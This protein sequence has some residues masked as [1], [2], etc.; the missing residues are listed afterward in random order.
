M[1]Q[2]QPTKK[3]GHC[4]HR[5]QLNPETVRPQVRSSSLLF[6]LLYLPPGEQPVPH[7]SPPSSKYQCFLQLK[8]GHIK[9]K[10]SG[11]YKDNQD[12]KPKKHLQM[13]LTYDGSTS[14][15]FTSH[16]C[17]SRSHSVGTILGIWDLQFF[18]G[19]CYVVQ[20]SL[21]MLGRARSS[22]PA[23][24]PRGNTTNTRTNILHPCTRPFCWHG[25][26]P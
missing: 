10:L 9:T 4:L 23:T 13:F 14:N 22:W 7:S 19:S 2:T 18:L 26:Q 3:R 16:R 11:P 8:D 12:G 17:E 21:V 24:G 25:I 5:S 15:F 1:N 20:S 6:C